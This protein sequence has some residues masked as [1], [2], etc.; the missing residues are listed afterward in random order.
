MVPSDVGPTVTIPFGEE[1][2][3]SMEELV[4]PSRADGDA[5]SKRSPCDHQ[6]TREEVARTWPV[7]VT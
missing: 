4:D 6:L 3:R 2:S 7:W 1:Y 5:M